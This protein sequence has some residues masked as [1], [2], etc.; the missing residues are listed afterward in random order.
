MKHYN[1]RIAAF[2][3]IAVMI[4]IV[5]MGDREQNIAAAE[6]PAATAEGVSLSPTPADTWMGPTMRPQIETGGVETPLITVTPSVSPVPTPTPSATAV[7][8]PV[9]TPAPVKE[10]MRGVWVAFYEYEKAGLKNKSEKIFRKN[11]DKLFKKIKEN[12]CNAVFFHVR[13][14]D[15]AIWPSE[16]FKFSTYMGKKCPDYDPLEIL[17]TSAHKYGLKFHAWMNPYRI[18][19]KKIYDPAKKSTTSR[20]QL[21][22]RE[23]IDN[24][25]VDG[26]HFDDYF[27]PGSGHKQ[28][29]KYASLSNKKKKA[30]VNKMVQTI[31]RGIKTK[32]PDVLF[33][34]SPA[35]NVEYSES[36]GADVK[37]WMKEPGY[38][39]YIAPQIYWSNNYRVGK[40][41]VR[42]FDTRFSKWKRL[43]KANIPMYIGLALYRGGMKDA[44]DRG[45][46]KNNKV[47][48]SQIS[49]IRRSEK[50]YGYILFSYESLYKKTCRYE[51]QNMLKRI[52]RVKVKKVTKDGTTRFKTTVYPARLGQTVIWKSSN[53]AI[54][55]INNKGKVSVKKS[56]IVK[57]TVQKAGKKVSVKLNTE[58]M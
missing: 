58:D 56:G 35:G 46:R 42:M 9:I 53:P 11:A 33:G 54:A 19:Q 28:Y 17:V 12:G 22:V 15:D 47:I 18:T 32:N 10:E 8:T 48:A 25:D 23:V 49:K 43:N 57:F 13:A 45:W 4:S 44:S 51:V 41:T 2:L 1:K 31:Y 26:I 7:P 34:I 36:L 38:L 50:V 6:L 14:F 55:S 37:T 16:H 21:A 24:Y 20:I 30:N 29:K 5:N 52:V 40:K 39:D 3:I 27:Y